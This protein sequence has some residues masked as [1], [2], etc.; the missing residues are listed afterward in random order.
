[1]PRDTT[2]RTSV[3]APHQ[4]TADRSDKYLSYEFEADWGLGRTP[5][6][7]NAG[8]I[9]TREQLIAKLALLRAGQLSLPDVRELAKATELIIR[10]VS[11]DSASQLARLPD[12]IE[13]IFDGPTKH[14]AQNLPWEVVG[15]GSSGAAST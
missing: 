11:A 4:A 1:M 10:P 8:D 15:F 3:R 5:T 12:H 7:W 6:L 9:V 13:L 14:L 2:I